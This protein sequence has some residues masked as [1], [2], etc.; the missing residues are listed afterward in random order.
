VLASTG[1]DGVFFEA[2]IFPFVYPNIDIV[3]SCYLLDYMFCLSLRLSFPFACMY[4]ELR[5][6]GSQLLL[7]DLSP[8]I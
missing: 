6:S 5:I 3:W 8:R 2:I 4:S 1:S 7:A